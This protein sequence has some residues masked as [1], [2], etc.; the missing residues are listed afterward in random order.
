MN[1]KNK[2]GDNF[3][4]SLT[5]EEGCQEQPGIYFQEKILFLQLI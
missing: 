3:S 2:A 5:T 1:F 4:C